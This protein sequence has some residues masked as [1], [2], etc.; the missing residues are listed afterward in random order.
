MSEIQRAPDEVGVDR[1]PTALL[2][3][4]EALWRGHREGKASRQHSEQRDGGVHLRAGRRSHGSTNDPASMLRVR[5]EGH[6]ELMPPYL[7]GPL[8]LYRVQ[9]RHSGAG[10]CGEGQG[11]AG[12]SD[13]V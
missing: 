6:L 1:C 13:T 5:D 12:H 3:S 4:H 7:H 9:P 11:S 2:E 10:E 8:D